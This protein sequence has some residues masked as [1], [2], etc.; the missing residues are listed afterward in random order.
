M[1]PVAPP[2]G[3]G[4][5]SSPF[6]DARSVALL[7]AAMA[8]LLVSEAFGDAARLALRY[9]RTGLAQGEWWRLLTAHFV[10]LD[11]KHAVMNALGLALLWALFVREY[12]A[13]RWFA[14]VLAS[15]VAIGAGL[16]FLSPEIEWYVGASGVLHGVMAA[17][18]LA[19]IRRGERLG[20]ALGLL[21][22]VKLAFEA[23]RGPLP[24]S[25]DLPVVTVAHLYGALGGFAAAL[26]LRP[27]TE[28]L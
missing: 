20:W 16:W 13:G 28:S 21:L 22:V 17:G 18:A 24:F 19:W 27:R 11:V 26:C 5:H 6:G 12:S 2:R 1:T 15:I 4:R 23:L 14:I 8:L 3:S 25:A 10:H 7:L 9:E